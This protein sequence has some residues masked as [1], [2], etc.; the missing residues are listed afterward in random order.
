MAHLVSGELEIILL[1]LSM[2]FSVSLILNEDLSY[3]YTYDTGEL[4]NFQVKK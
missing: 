1:I 4:L 2:S 3:K